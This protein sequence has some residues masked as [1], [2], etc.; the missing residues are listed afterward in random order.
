VS[1][2]LTYSENTET[3]APLKKDDATTL[4]MNTEINED[5]AKYAHVIDPKRGIFNFDINVND[6]FDMIK[7]YDEEDLIV[8]LVNRLKPSHTNALV[9]F[10]RKIC[11]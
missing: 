6:E 9:N 5:N 10:K 3:A 1:V 7:T 4:I 11:K 2:D 8:E